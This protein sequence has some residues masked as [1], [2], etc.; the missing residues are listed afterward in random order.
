M[1]ES[2]TFDFAPPLADVSKIGPCGEPLPPVQGKATGAA[3]HCSAMGAL[4]AKGFA[5]FQREK[6]LAAYETHGPLTDH[7][8][9]AE[10]DIDR[11]SVCARRNEL[12]KLG[13]VE[14]D[15]GRVRLN[16]TT[17]VNNTLWRLTR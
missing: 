8:M 4:K 5:A 2:L 9:E 14:K 16:P 15:A 10:T 3:L 17:G 11:S 13:Q 1:A 6:L 7:E 12:I